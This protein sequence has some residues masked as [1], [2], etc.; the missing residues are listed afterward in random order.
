M[1]NDLNCGDLLKQ[2]HDEMEKKANNKFRSLDLTRSQMVVLLLLNRSDQKQMPLKALEHRLHVAQSTAAGI[3]GRL[4]Q[5][6]LIEAV[7]DPTDKR[8]KILHITPQGMAFCQT[9]E[10]DMENGEQ[11]LLSALTETE[12]IVF[13]SLLIKIRN[14]L[15]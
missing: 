1:S 9:A 6:G 12:Q 3:V 15:K 11:E 2:I 5:K 13:K 14:S 7:G 8:I 4:E 10:R